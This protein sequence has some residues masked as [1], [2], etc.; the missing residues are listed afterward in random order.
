MWRWI[1]V[2]DLKCM[3]W[4]PIEGAAWWK[5]LWW[6]WPL[7]WSGGGLVGK[8]KESKL[9]RSNNL[10]TNRSFTQITEIRFW[11]DGR[12]IFCF[13]IPINHNIQKRC[14]EKVMSKERG[15]GLDWPIGW[16][17]AKSSEE[18]RKRITQKEN[19]DIWCG[20]NR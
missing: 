11:S 20:L 12:L 9:L 6:C 18:G 5:N 2:T 14:R 19:L 15:I 17:V 16:W 8:K 3:E 13:K 10:G 7:E 1:D 4:K